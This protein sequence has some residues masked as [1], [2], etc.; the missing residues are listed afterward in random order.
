MNTASP[1]V[2]SSMSSVIGFDDFPF[3]R[4]H[5]G[6]VQVVGTVYTGLRLEGI[7]SGR[8]RRDGVNATDRL[9]HLIRG[10][11]F[12]PQLRL[13]M[14]QGI[15]LGGFNVVDIHGLHQRLNIPV[16]V[17]ARKAPDL[18]AIEDAL[19]NR[20]RGGARKW[21]LIKRAGTMEPI[22]G[23][24]VQ[25]AGL[26]LKEAGKVIER[27]AVCGRIPEPLRIAHLIAGGIGVG[28]GKGRPY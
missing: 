19:L 17:V 6:D 3:P 14:L 28:Q 27:F 7:I 24:Y 2:R 9:T 15:A 10:S 25:R 11:R 21:R 4:T 23:V 16:L 1:I 18:R 5:R 22:S 12:A 20:V 13:V 26:T 8:I